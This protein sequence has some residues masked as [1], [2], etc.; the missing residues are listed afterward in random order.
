MRLCLIL[1]C[2]VV[3]CCITREWYVVV[4][5]RVWRVQMEDSFDSREGSFK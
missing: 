1:V 3:L 4:L 2:Y 5:V